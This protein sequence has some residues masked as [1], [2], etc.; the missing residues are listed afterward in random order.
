MAMVTIISAFMNNRWDLALS[1]G[2]ILVFLG[3]TAFRPMAIPDT[4]AYADFFFSVDKFPYSLS[5]QR[6]Y[7]GFETGYTNISKIIALFST[8]P[9]VYFLCIASI[10]SVLSIIGIRML[11]ATMLT[12][13]VSEIPILPVTLIFISYYGFMYTSIVLRAG[14]GLSLCWVAYAYLFQKKYIRALLLAVL[15]ILFHK[16]SILFFILALFYFVLPLFSKKTYLIVLSTI[17]VLYVLRAFDKLNVFFFQLLNLIASRV[18]LLSFLNYY[19]ALEIRESTFL[20][21]ILFFMLQWLYIGL[22]FTDNTSSF[23]RR[24]MGVAVVVSFFSALF[25]SLPVVTRG[26]DMVFFIVLPS[27][28]ATYLSTERKNYFQVIPAIDSKKAIK[29]DSIFHTVV[30]LGIVS[31]NFLLFG[32][33]SGLFRISEIFS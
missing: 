9:R 11:T 17:V 15:A 23:Q 20:L 3:L 19:L 14:L 7:D 5:F 12:K 33:W 28:I 32:R 4:Q 26:L 2:F 1:I 30:F 13:Q 8:S 10:T 16:S 25:G 21:T 29:L 22:F 31:I 27:I 18:S 24:N 6:H